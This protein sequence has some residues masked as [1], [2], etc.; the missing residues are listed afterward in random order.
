MRQLSEAEEKGADEG[1]SNSEAS[2][3][4]EA[5]EREF[6]SE[7]E[8]MGDGTDGAGFRLESLYSAYGA[9]LRGTAHRRLYV[10]RRP[11]SMISAVHTAK[12]GIR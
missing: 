2:K 12:A 10:S 5:L 9:H 11:S 7:A 1:D 3:L 4:I 6:H 8:A